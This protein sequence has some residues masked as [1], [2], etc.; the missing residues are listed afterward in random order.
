MSSKM[1]QAWSRWQMPAMH[2]IPARHAAHDEDYVD[3]AT[4]AMPRHDHEADLAALREAARQ[5]GW[6]Q[7]LNE[8]RQ[9]ARGELRLQAE[10][11]QQ[12]IRHFSQPL[13]ALNEQVEEELLGLAFALARQVVGET[14]AAEPERVLTTLREAVAALPASSRHVRV[15]LHPEDVHLVRENLPSGD[16]VHWQLIEDATITRGGCR[17]ESGSARIDAR[18]ETRLAEAAQ[19]LDLPQPVPLRVVS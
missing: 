1:A 13:A 5:E 7:G 19:R 3:V 2:D 8:G 11:W 18:V 12:L 9:A 17:L 16:D 10:R 15:H 4:A 14:L 6:M